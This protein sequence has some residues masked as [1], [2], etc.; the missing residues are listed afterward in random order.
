MSN[1]QIAGVAGMNA[2][3]NNALINIKG[4]S[5]LNPEER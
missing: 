2:V 1:A 5:K 4:E 3:E